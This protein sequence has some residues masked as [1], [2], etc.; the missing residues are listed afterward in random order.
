MERLEGRSDEALAVAAREGSEE[1][2]RVLVERFERPIFGLLLRIVRRPELA[3]DLA[4]ETFLKAH[5]ALARF[6]A[7][8]KFSSWL[9]KI[10]HNAALD[11]LRRSRQEPLLSLDTTGEEGE[12]PPAAA[13]PAA[14]NPFDR[15]AG[16]DLGRALDDA[17]RSLKPQYREILLLRFG[18]ELSYDE[19]SEV[20]DLP[21]GTVKIHL[22]RARRD[23]ARALAGRGWDPAEHGGGGRE[24]RN[25]GAGPA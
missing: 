15:L 12:S 9:F 16:R 4:Q 3:E 19:L 22:F 24:R 17:L 11:A 6:D 23:L 7:N 5:R 14:E 10:A 8:R 2:F 13:D 18:E 20:L 1:A 25:K 21:L